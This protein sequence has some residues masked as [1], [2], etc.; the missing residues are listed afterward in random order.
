MRRL[1][2]RQGIGSITPGW[3]GCRA[4]APAASAVSLSYAGDTWCLSAFAAS[5]T[6]RSAANWCPSRGRAVLPLCRTAACAPSRA[7]RTPGKAHARHGSTTA[8]PERAPAT[9][10]ADD[11]L[12]WV[13]P[14][15]RGIELEIVALD[16][17]D[18]FVVLRDADKPAEV[19]R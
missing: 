6:L 11:R 15:D 14:D 4:R 3:T 18:T 7:R 13:G 10:A 12:V 1:Q 2:A 5:L 19:E 17:D 16:L 8:E 9:E